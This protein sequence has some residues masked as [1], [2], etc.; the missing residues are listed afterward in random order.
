MIQF[1]PFEKPVNAIKTLLSSSYEKEY[2]A[3]SKLSG[4][5][6]AN[7]PQ[8]IVKVGGAN[9]SS[10]AAILCCLDI[11][12]IACQI[13]FIDTCNTVPP[14]TRDVFDLERELKRR[15]SE[16]YH[17]FRDRSLAAH[18]DEIG[19]GV[20]LL[21][22]DAAEAMPYP[23]LDFVAAF[24]YLTPNAIVAICE[25][26]PRN[27][28]DNVLI[29]NVTADKFSGHSPSCLDLQSCIQFITT[30]TVSIFQV[31]SY[32]SEHIVD[33]FAALKLPWQYMLQ[34]DALLEYRKF[35]KTHYNSVCLELYNQAVIEA[36]PYKK[37]LKAMEQSL[38]KTFPQVLLYGK[39]KRGQYF[40]SL[41]D[42][43]GIPVSGFV[44][45]DGRSSETE[46]RNYPVYSYSGIP[47][48]PNDVFIFQTAASEEV[49]QRL[50][51]SKY[52]WMGFP[53]GFWED[54]EYKE[55]LSTVIPHMENAMKSEGEGRPIWSK[56]KLNV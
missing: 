6:R 55:Y 17:M 18:M 14:Y 48:H 35:I 10:S 7:Q 51:Q 50:Y 25:A 40:L 2:A 16:K 9:S 1:D 52:H 43:I 32:T 11:V 4:L 3:L 37:M 41:L 46:Y 39:G 26:I 44:V 30:G 23:I 21:I 31:N 42:L 15:D 20:D 56:G 13:Y 8:K 28:S 5:I 19:E 47:F 45:S 27:S 29:Q 33:L 24:P 38:L 49:Q 34:L 22:L 12:Q 54:F 53:E 36:D